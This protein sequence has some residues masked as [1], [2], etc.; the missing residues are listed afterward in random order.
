MEK[1]C[2]LRLV[3]HDSVAEKRTGRDSVIDIEVHLAS[4]TMQT[5]AGET[6][7]ENRYQPMYLFYRPSPLSAHSLLATN[8]RMET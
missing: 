5:R 3:F 6:T 7:G 8:M 2:L 4:L 1:N